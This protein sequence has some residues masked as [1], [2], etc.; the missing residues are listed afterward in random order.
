M[1]PCLVESGRAGDAVICRLS[2]F[3]RFFWGIIMPKPCHLP[4][5]NVLPSS[6]VLLADR[7]RAWR[8]QRDIPI[9]HAAGELGVSAA[10]WD[11]WEKGRRF[12]SM[13]DLNLLAQYLCLP[14]CLL[15]CPLKQSQCGYCPKKDEP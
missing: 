15:F 5:S 12:P 8:K 7:L 14:P 1:H 9:K 4:G 13:N 11:H 6:G 2:A 3:E 10:T